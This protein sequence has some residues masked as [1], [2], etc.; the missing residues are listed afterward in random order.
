MTTARSQRISTTP[1]AK[2][3]RNAKQDR[4]ESRAA[5]RLASRT[6]EIVVW[7]NATPAP[8]P[9]FFTSMSLAL[10]LGAPMRRM[11]AALRWLGWRRIV[12]RIR[13]T[14]V[15]LWLPPSTTLKTRPRGRP[16]VYAG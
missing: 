1:D 9:E 15:P 16:R 13:G 4:N 11:A 7:W 3:R 5:R 12:R 2:R 14:Q 8:R 10:S 6:A